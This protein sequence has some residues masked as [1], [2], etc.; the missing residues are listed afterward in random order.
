V[1]PLGRSKQGT[2]D[3]FRTVGENT[4]IA[5]EVATHKVTVHRSKTPGS[6]LDLRPGADRRLIREAGY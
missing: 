3:L 1:K 2:H 6:G 4:I 5:V